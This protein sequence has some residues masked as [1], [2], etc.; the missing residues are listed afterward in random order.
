MH[1]CVVC[2]GTLRRATRSGCCMKCARRHT[3]ELCGL[4]DPAIPAWTWCPPCREYVTFTLAWLLV[5]PFELALPD[6]AK[7]LALY[8][9]R[10]AEGLPLF[11]EAS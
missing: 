6:R 3:C 11:R 8:E 4:C 9:A 1:Q 10:A 7:R 5:P 2:N